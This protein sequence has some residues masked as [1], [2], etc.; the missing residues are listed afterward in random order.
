VVVRNE[1]DIVFAK[2]WI[3]SAT[4]SHLQMKQMEHR[5][6]LRVPTV[7]SE[8][9]GRYHAL[10]DWAESKDN[11]LKFRSVPLYPM[12]DM[13]LE[14]ALRIKQDV[15]YMKAGRAAASDDFPFETSGSPQ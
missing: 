9:Y 8:Q 14:E 12:H 2:E 7:T 4:E 6:Y 13:D 11:P 1:K 10:W 5:K 15:D 3:Q